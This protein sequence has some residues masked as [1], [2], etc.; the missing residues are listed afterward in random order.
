M[1]QLDSMGS[2][3]LHLDHC[4]KMCSGTLSSHP[5]FSI[6]I[7]CSS[8]RYECSLGH[9]FNRWK[10]DNVESEMVIGRVPLD[11]QCFYVLSSPREE[12]SG[13]RILNSTLMVGPMVHPPLVDVLMSFRRHNVALIADVSRMYRAVCLTESDKRFV[14]RDNIDDILLDFRVTLFWSVRLLVHIEHASRMQWISYPPYP[15]CPSKLTPPSTLMTTLEELTHQRKQSNF[16]E[17]Y[18]HYSTEV[19]SCCVNGILQWSDHLEEC[20]FWAQGFSSHYS[21]LWDWTVHKKHWESSGTHPTTISE[22]TLS[23]FHLLNVWP[24]EHSYLMSPRHLM[25]SAGSHLRT[26]VKAKMLLQLI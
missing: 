15:R 12:N 24:R 13:L 22:S 2:S 19:V 16:N 21:P 10:L 4:F 5:T 3:C 20:L 1:W 23:S 18:S 8:I 9:T 14:W 25:S 11:S 17:R 26:N 6:Q 7:S